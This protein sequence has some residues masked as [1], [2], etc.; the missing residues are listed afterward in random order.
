MDEIVAGRRFRDA[1]PTI[2][3]HPA[4]DWVVGELFTGADG[5]RYARVYSFSN[6]HDRKTLSTAIL[7]DKRRFVQV[8]AGALE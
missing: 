6:P 4:P 1:A 8:H 3:G 2:F 7:R 5:M